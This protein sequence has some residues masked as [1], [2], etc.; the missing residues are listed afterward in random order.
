M[1]SGELRLLQQD[2]QLLIVHKPAGW[3]IYAED[4]VPKSQHLQHV[5]QDLFGQKLFPIHRLDRATCGI[6]VFATDG[7]WARE[8]QEQF[9][10]RKVTKIYSALIEG[11]LRK[12]QTINIALKE[13]GKGEQS[14][15]TLIVPKK[16]GILNGL[17]VTLVD[18]T[19]HTGRFHQLRKHCKLLG[20]PIIG[21][22]LYANQK[23]VSSNPEQ[24]E[25]RLMLSA[26]ELRFFHPRTKKEI[27]IKDS[28]D[29]E[30]TEI[31]KQAKIRI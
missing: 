30:Y 12:S 19:P 7:R 28:P 26:V 8:M 10:K 29:F 31:L 16:T 17:E 2:G 21:D 6:V 1:A 14:A 20:H 27:R 4:G 15:S 24:N 13:K 22:K 3:T 18:L 9:A 11:N 5:C 25:L 23:K